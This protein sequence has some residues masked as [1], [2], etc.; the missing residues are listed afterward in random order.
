MVVF[1]LLLQRVRSK[2][3]GFRSTGTGVVQRASR[4]HVLGIDTLNN[5]EHMAQHYCKF[6]EITM[7][8]RIFVNHY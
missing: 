3:M 5:P 6:Y 2:E 8:R 7:R 4:A 1:A